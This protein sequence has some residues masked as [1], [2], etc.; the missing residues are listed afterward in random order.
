MRFNRFVISCAWHKELVLWKRYKS[1]E[2]SVVVS[3][4]SI[5]FVSSKKTS[6]LGDKIPSLRCRFHRS[7]DH[8]CRGDDREVSVFILGPLFW[9]EFRETERF[10]EEG[11]LNVIRVS[12]KSF[13]EIGRAHV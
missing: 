8:E 11:F 10:F 13:C 5:S 9:P 7:F 2:H 3:K 6:P 4:P 12:L 1:V